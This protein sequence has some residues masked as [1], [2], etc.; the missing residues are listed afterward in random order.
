MVNPVNAD[1]RLLMKA[2]CWPRLTISLHPFG[3]QDSLSDTGLGVAATR[4]GNDC[5][6]TV[7]LEPVCKLCELVD[8]ATV[9]E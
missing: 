7:A 9:N 1:G 6:A 2:S 4:F 3:I 5:L 8:V